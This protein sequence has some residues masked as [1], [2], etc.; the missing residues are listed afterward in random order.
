MAKNIY[1]KKY[2]AIKHIE[3]KSIYKSLRSLDTIY[4]E[5]NIQSKIHHPKIVK[6]LFVQETEKDFDLVMEYAPKGNL[7]FYIQKNRCLSESKSFQF[8]IQIVNAIHFLH[9]NNYIHKDIKPENILLFDNNIV[10]LCYFGWCVEIKDRPRKTYCGTTE[11]IAPE[12]INETFYG[13]EI[14]N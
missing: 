4:T 9:K 5:I 11:Y 12:M 13:K 8:F 2:Y 6:I 7:F 14:D 1:D 3:K 10:K